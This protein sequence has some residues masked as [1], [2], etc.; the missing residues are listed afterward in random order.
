MTYP[1]PQTPGE[2]RRGGNSRETYAKK[3]TIII[4]IIPGNGDVYGIHLA[5]DKDQWR[6]LVN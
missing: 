4:K 5:Q 3:E 1:N 2:T 6:V